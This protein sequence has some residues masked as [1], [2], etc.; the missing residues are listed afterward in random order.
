MGDP[1]ATNEPPVERNVAPL[2]LFL[3]LLFP[4]VIFSHFYF[5]TYFFGPFSIILRKGD[6]PATN[7]PPAKRNVGAVIYG[8]PHFLG[9]HFYFLAIFTRLISA[10]LVTEKGIRNEHA[11][12]N[13]PLLLQLLLVYLSAVASFT[14][15]PVFTRLAFF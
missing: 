8:K 13:V 5:L 6:Q 7:K 9:S 11:E 15:W 2:L 14:F 1:A 10:W 3:L 12:R 4:V